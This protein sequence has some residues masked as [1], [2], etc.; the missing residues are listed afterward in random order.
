MNNVS[1][2]SRFL[3]LRQEFSFFEYQS[4][5]FREENEAYRLQFNFNLGNK[6]YFHSET[7]IP[8]K[9]FLKLPQNVEQLNWL[10]FNI[11]MVELISYWKLACPEKVNHR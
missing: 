9:S 11:G 5:S 4:Y 3:Q 2:H 1:N 7:L 6:F 8:K 10:V